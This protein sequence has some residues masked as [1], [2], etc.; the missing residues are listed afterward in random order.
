MALGARYR[1]CYDTTE[2]AVQQ[3]QPRSL[4]GCDI[5]GAR[6]PIKGARYT[7]PTGANRHGPKPM[8]RYGCEIENTS[9][10]VFILLVIFKVTVKTH[11][12][13]ISQRVRM[14]VYTAVVSLFASLMQESTQRDSLSRTTK[15]EYQIAFSL[16]PGLENWCACICTH[17]L[18]S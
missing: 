12:V 11:R 3:K 5:C 6:R 13:P 7:R 18:H 4:Y 15:N 10:G 16:H 17:D 1:G 9:G 14:R 8:L 2:T